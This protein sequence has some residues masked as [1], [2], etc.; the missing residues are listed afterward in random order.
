MTECIYNLTCVFFSSNRR[1]SLY[2]VNFIDMRSPNI[3]LFCLSP[4]IASFA[5]MSILQLYEKGFEQ[6]S[7]EF[8]MTLKNSC[9][10]LKLHNSQFSLSDDLTQIPTYF[11]EKKSFMTKAV[12]NDMQLSQSMC[13]CIFLQVSLCGYMCIC[14]YLHVY[15]FLLVCMCIYA[16]GC[17]RLH[18][19]AY[20]SMCVSICIYVY[21]CFSVCKCINT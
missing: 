5:L 21:L 2:F 4:S 10:L 3:P 11:F 19:Y 9:I 8:R 7:I 14:V 12:L 20:V 15:V 17:A 18:V 1:C 13:V 16:S 6:Y